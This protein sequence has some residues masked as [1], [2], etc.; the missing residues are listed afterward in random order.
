MVLSMI[1]VYYTRQQDDISALVFIIDMEQS[2]G[3][4]DI[5]DSVGLSYTRQQAAAQYIFYKV[6]QYDGLVGMIRLGYYPDYIL[7]ATEDRIHIAQY[8]KSLAIAPLSTQIVYEAPW[9]SLHDIILLSWVQYV[10]LTDKQTTKQAVKRRN[11]SIQ[12]VMIGQDIKTWE[13]VK[14]HSNITNTKTRHLWWI[15]TGIIVLWLLLL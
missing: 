12:T 7:P 8:A 11:P 3:E 15:L 14:D 2:M 4:K 10:L 6:E 5:R 9:L 13:D 1:F